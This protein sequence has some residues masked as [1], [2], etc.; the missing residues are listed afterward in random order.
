MVFWFWVGLTVIAVPPIAYG[1]LMAALF[2][3]I[4]WKYLRFLVRIFQERPLFVVPR[5]QPIDGAEEVTVPA[6][7]GLRCAAA[8]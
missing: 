3:Y 5:G 2:L 7:D 6:A 8:T 1:L 4:R